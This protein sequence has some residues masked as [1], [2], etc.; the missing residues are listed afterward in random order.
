MTSFSP[1]LNGLT[2]EL[3]GRCDPKFQAVAD[4]IDFVVTAV[5]DAIIQYFALLRRA[6]AF[7]FRLH[8]ND[9]G[10]KKKY[11]EFKISWTCMKKI[12]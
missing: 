9:S 11:I 7:V 1:L 8:F 10:K 12:N 6:I 4:A 2:P 3:S 5:F